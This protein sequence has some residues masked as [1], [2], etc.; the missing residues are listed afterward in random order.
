[1]GAII[2]ASITSTMSVPFLKIGAVARAEGQAEETFSLNSTFFKEIE[3]EQQRKL[4]GSQ[5]VERIFQQATAAAPMVISGDN[6]YVIWETNETGN[7]EVMF[8]ASN[9]GGETFGDRVNL[10]NSTNLDSY[11]AYVVGSGDRVLVSW[12]ENNVT[13][14][15]INY[16]LRTS[17][18]GGK[19]FGD[20]MF[21]SAA[22]AIGDRVSDFLTFTN[23]EFGFKVKHP[24]DWEIDEE[25]ADDPSDGAGSVVG[26]YSPPENRLDD[27]RERIWVSID[28]L[29]RNN[30]T[31]EEYST[32]VISQQNST[33]NNFTL[34]DSDTD[35]TV[36]AGHPGYRI[37]STYSLEDERIVKQMEVGTILG[38]MVY[39]VNYYAI[40]N[41]YDDYLPVIQD[42]ISSLEIEG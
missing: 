25:G 9:D 13:N 26:F 34:I 29:Q 30:M 40:E 14:S 2:I 35:S 6:V 20:P 11:N 8:R 3:Q 7:H 33:L 39:Y 41:S 4:A 24:P 19:T 10:S 18:D 32:E 17:E 37:V 42:V 27:Y 38:N 16:I 5:I 23:P 22:G 21:L 1:L 31:I 12:Q 36:L 28:T 15:T